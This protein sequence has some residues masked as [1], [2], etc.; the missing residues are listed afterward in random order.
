MAAADIYCTGTQNSDQLGASLKSYSCME[1][2][3]FCRRLETR[4]PVFTGWQAWEHLCI[5]LWHRRLSRRIHQC[6]R[7]QTGTAFTFSPPQWGKKCSW[8][9]LPVSE[10][11]Y[12][13]AG[14]L[15]RRQSAIALEWSWLM[16]MVATSWTW[17][18]YPKTKG[19]QIPAFT[20]RSV[21][22]YA[23]RTHGDH[24]GS[25]TLPAWT[26]MDRV[27]YMFVIRVLV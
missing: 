9:T 14:I 20:I 5:R 25:I 16:L 10:K 21:W 15:R 8:T 3:F 26:N 27:C 4:L 1:E 13:S 18:L 12:P 6:H 7:N 19:T 22:R 2:F 23:W 11:A 24:H 17:Q